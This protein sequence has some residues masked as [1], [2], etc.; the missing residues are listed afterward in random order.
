MTCFHL[1]IKNESQVNKNQSIEL[2]TTIP[3]INDNTNEVGSIEN[4]FDKK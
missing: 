2:K 1:F 4:P 3:A